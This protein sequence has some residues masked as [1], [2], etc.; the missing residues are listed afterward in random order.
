MYFMKK[1]IIYSFLI[2]P[3]FISCQKEISIDNGNTPAP[4]PTVGDSTYLTKI[5]AAEFYGAGL[6][7]FGINTVFYDNLKRVTSII[8]SLKQPTL[9][10][11]LS[12]EYFYSFTD[13]LPYKS[14]KK[15]YGSSGA[16]S[17]TDTFF[18]FYNPGARR[19]KDSIIR[20]GSVNPGS[21]DKTVTVI[22]YQYTG[23]SILGQTV[24]TSFPTSG[25]SYLSRSDQDN[26]TLD[27]NG[28]IIL[29]IK[30]VQHHYFG[31]GTNYD[32]TR[33]VFTYDNKLSPWARLTAHNAFRIFPFGETFIYEFA[34]K[35]N[36]L[37]S[38]ELTYGSTSHHYID[39]LT[40]AYT[41]NTFNYPKYI[42]I[43]DPQ[44]PVFYEKDVFIYRA[45]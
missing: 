41:F 6:D 7:T 23:N 5:Y 16:L 3:V 15:G 17:Q 45:F 38:D 8:D 21:W 44:N 1:M 28:N 27:A 25:P 10:I 43:P 20:P 40:G 14:I 30:Y 24:Q 37:K 2:L 39:D 4:N 29:N 34:H 22:N 32:T 12:T 42:T 31:G 35:N 11:Q 33:S 13:T 9:V 19:I 26:A 36:V 18:H